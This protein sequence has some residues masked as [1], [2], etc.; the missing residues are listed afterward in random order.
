M[1]CYALCFHF[2]RPLLTGSG[3]PRQT[4]RRV[5]MQACARCTACEGGLTLQGHKAREKQLPWLVRP[6]SS[7]SLFAVA[8]S[9]LYLSA[10]IVYPLSFTICLWSSLASLACNI[11]NICSRPLVHLICPSRLPVFYYCVQDSQ[12]VS[13]A[14][15]GCTVWLEERR[16][17]F[18]LLC[19]HVLA[20]LHI[21]SFGQFN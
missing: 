7:F 12:Q 11:D 17:S 1:W 14:N 10:L 19:F 21:I 2:C 4:D 3:P 8:C 13:R 9:P 6:L 15:I 16:L 18:Y 20:D 5:K